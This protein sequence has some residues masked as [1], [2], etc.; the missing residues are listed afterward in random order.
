MLDVELSFHE[1]NFTAQM[2]QTLNLRI[3]FKDTFADVN[4]NLN[5][6][7]CLMQK[8]DNCVFLIYFISVEIGLFLKG[9]ISCYFCLLPQVHS[10]GQNI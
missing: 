2:W 4:E 1:S 6:L 10:S 5:F 9:F 3:T 8:E 7:I